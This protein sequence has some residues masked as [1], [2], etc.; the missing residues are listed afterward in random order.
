MDKFREDYGTGRRQMI[1]AFVA[2]TQLADPP[3]LGPP[4]P[5]GEALR[6]EITR[7]HGQFFDGN[8]ACKRAFGTVVLIAEIK[9]WAK[10]DQGP[11]PPK[12]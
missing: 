11:P 12:R 6:D 1:D 10:H 5:T 8:V 7:L 3:G 4:A 2:M 9:V